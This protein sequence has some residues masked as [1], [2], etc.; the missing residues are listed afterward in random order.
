MQKCSAILTVGVLWALSAAALERPD[1]TFKIFQFPA[2]QIPRVDGDVSD[3]GMVPVDYAIG[4]DQLKDTVHDSQ[5][6]TTDLDVT[7]H[8]PTIDKPTRVQKNSASL[9]DNS[10]VNNPKQVLISVN[11]VTD[12]SDH[13]SQFCILTST[14]NKIKRK[15]IKR[16]ELSHFN[17][18][19]LNSDL[20]T[21]DWSCI[22]KTHANNVDKLFSTFY[23]NSIK[24]IGLNNFLSLG[25]QKV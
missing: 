10:F 25:L 8:L 4:I 16:R 12:V 18:D 6:D 2:D 9:I 19:S 13:F 23:R 15:Q 11:L 14:R 24:I 3:W 21:I 20:A 22:I 17:R 7:M 1:T 5:I